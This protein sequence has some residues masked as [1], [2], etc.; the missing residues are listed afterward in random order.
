MLEV[1]YQAIVYFRHHMPG[2][3]TSHYPG[4]EG[5]LGN[6]NTPLHLAG[7]V[8]SLD[9]YLTLALNELDRV[10]TRVATLDRQIEPLGHQGYFS[11]DLI[12]G[13][14]QEI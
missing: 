11:N 4:L 8:Q 9:R 13:T 14:L 6:L 12:Y 10:Q 2:I 1:A 5:R 7:L 3:T